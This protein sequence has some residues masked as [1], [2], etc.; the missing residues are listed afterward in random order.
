MSSRLTLIVIAVLVAGIAV[1]AILFID[2]GPRR[3]TA[4]I[5]PL[6]QADRVAAFIA[7]F[8]SLTDARLHPTVWRSGT[9]LKT[10]FDEN[11][12]QWTLTVSPR[13]WA[14]R[15]EASK[16]DLG[17]TLFSALQAVRAQ[18]GGDPDLAVLVIEDDTGEVVLRASHE[19]GVVVRR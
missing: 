2:S 6:R 18:A 16:M 15:D 14:H 12:E 9:F 1:A 11:R 4:K 19:T 5:T 17:A 13:D 3:G 10:G 7:R 8:D